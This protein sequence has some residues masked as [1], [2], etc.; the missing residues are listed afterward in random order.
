MLASTLPQGHDFGID[1]RLQYFDWSGSL[2]GSA[3]A[4]VKH[5]PSSRVYFAD[6]MRT[7]KARSPLFCDELGSPLAVVKWPLD[8]ARID[9]WC[10]PDME[11]GRVLLALCSEHVQVV[12]WVSDWYDLVL[13][14]LHV[15]SATLTIAATDGYLVNVAH[16]WDR[17]LARRPDAAMS[18]DQRMG[19]EQREVS[20][21]LTDLALLRHH[22]LPEG[23]IDRSVGPGSLASTQHVGLSF[24]ATLSGLRSGRRLR[25]AFD[26]ERWLAWLLRRAGDAPHLQLFFARAAGC[27]AWSR[28]R[29][30]WAL[31]VVTAWSDPYAVPIALQI[32]AS[33][34][35]GEA[36]LGESRTLAHMSDP[37]RDWYLNSPGFPMTRQGANLI[38]LEFAAALGR[39]LSVR[40]SSG[41][42]EALVALDAIVLNSF[43]VG[44]LGPIFASGLFEALATGS[45]RAED[46]EL[47]DTLAMSYGMTNVVD[48]EAAE[49]E[50]WHSWAGEAHHR[51][52][53]R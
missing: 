20:P 8:L 33:A 12:L 16:S 11:G 35:D 22:P 32:L 24:F 15:S 1:Y 26:H 2:V 39:F 44:A 6:E 19:W 29:R 34:P 38:D 45:E 30:A 13:R 31:E 9:S 5:L 14:W 52:S 49:E 51:Y 40:A 25:D 27:F 21:P 3:A 4:Q 47:W 28:V 18:A 23:W 41:S 43:E 37:G 7:L 50:F 10:Q 36:Q 42:R 17:R 48:R 46:R 53:S